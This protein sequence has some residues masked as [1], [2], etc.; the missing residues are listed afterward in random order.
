MKITEISVTFGGT[1]NLGDF[2]SA[3]LSVTFSALLDDGDDP[4]AARSLLMTMAQSAVREKAQEL[5]R[6]RKARVDEIFAGLPV[7]LQQQ[8]KG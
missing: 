5:Q 3:K 8:L 6:G 4:D 2:N 7:E 1:L